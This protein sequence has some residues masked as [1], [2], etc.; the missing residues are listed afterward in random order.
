MGL[1]IVFYMLF[2]HLGV[3]SLN[4]ANLNTFVLFGEEIISHGSLTH[5]WSKILK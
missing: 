2:R 5:I 1:S 3:I 4:G